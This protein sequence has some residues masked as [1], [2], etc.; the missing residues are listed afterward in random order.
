[1]SSGSW[2]FLVGKLLLDEIDRLG[3][4]RETVVS[5]L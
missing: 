3:P 1:M 5:H 2:V 4:H